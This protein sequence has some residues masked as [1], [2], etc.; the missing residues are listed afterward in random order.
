MRTF[1][2][3]AAVAASFATAAMAETIHV[4]VN[5]LVCAFCVKGI[6][7][8]FRKQPAVERIHVDLDNK[9]VTIN[10]KTD[11]T[12]DDATIKQLITDAGYT[13]TTIHHQK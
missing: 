1:V 11:Q 10:T 6:E 13:T 3:T 7:S 5:G 2:L 9:L 8:S 12:L 4:G